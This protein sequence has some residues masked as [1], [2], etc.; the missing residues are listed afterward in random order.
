M[1]AATLYV[2]PDGQDAW[3]GST[4][5]PNAAGTD[6]PLASLAG[7]RDAVRALRRAHPDE[8]VTVLFREGVYVFR[9]TVE[10][11]PADSGT[12]AA[13]IRY[14]AFAGET[15]VF[16]GGVP[17]TGWRSEGDGVVATTLPD[18]QD[19]T[20]TFR[21]L[22]ADGARQTRARCPN[23]DPQ[24]PYRK[25][26]FYVAAD[27]NGFGCTVGCIHNRGDWMKYEVNVP[28]GGQYTFWMRYGANNRQ[29]EWE[30][31]D[32]ATRTVLIAD[33]G[34]PIPLV[35]L[36]DTGGWTATRWSRSATL[37]LNKGTHTLVWKN[38]LGGGIN[39]DAY[40]LCDDPDW[41]PEGTE[42][43]QPAE[44]RH[45]VVIQAEKMTASQG[46]Q[47]RVSVGG[48]S[49]NKFPYREGDFN[50]EWASVPGA[51]VHIFQSGSCRAFKEILS[52]ESVDKE[53]RLVHVGGPET[54]AALRAGD[55]YFVENVPEELDAPG[56]WYLDTTSGVLRF[57]PDGPIQDMTVVAPTVCELVRLK[58][59]AE[60]GQPVESI[61]FSGFTI[62]YTGMTLNDG[63]AGYGM[64]TEGVFRWQNAADC[65]I[66]NCTFE[67]CGRYALAIVSS[68]RNEVKGCAIRDS[69]QGGVLVI[70]SDHCRITDNTM[71]RLG[72]I[73][74]H[75]GGV[76]L[77]GRK[78]SDNVV[79]HN[80]IRESSRYG[81]TCKMAGLR[82]LIASNAIYRMSTETYDT[83]GIEV[84]QHDREERSMSIIRNNL[85]VDVIGYS[86]SFETPVYMSWG[87]YLDSFA[88]GYTVENNVTV[89]S[90]YGVMIQGGK[91][92][93]LRNNIFVGG[94][95]AQ[96]IF[97][98]YAGN[99]Q[100]NVFERNIVYWDDP[101]AGFGRMGKDLEKTL[102]AD[103]NLFFC[104]G[105]PVAE[106]AEYQAWRNKGFD[107]HGLSADPLFVDPANDDY[108]LRPESPAFQL[109]F[110]PVDLSDIGPRE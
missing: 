60:S 9:E 74:K 30:T 57:M 21:Q 14:A 80:L 96:F 33:D 31:A 92:N 69:G 89:R 29:T 58:G 36:P 63:C 104:A 106:K 53:D 4:P 100:D 72:A 86:S 110:Q 67:N 28:E 42:L 79:A 5:A 20:W 59:D 101:D 105:A 75:I 70:D 77:T 88:G 43:K 32:M 85:V 46:R 97:A 16:Q 95:T 3:S 51:E 54:K 65:R 93:I 109:G 50:P 13:P 99:S 19:G 26:F 81:I 41:Q 6:G 1:N 98:N 11:T 15:P 12:R 17:I 66:E 49:P 103:R 22:F 76:V 37:R 34:K 48:G 52:I 84:T 73:Y 47:L 78:A 7:A 56:E 91:G 107:A 27:T 40:A 10:F 68:T 45:L 44:G 83:G 90:S 61:E 102:A 82:N 8:P 62:R 24:D 55:R 64:G 71:E 25:G 108:S 87:I 39:L 2:S 18:V 23:V 38:I 94:Q 35:D